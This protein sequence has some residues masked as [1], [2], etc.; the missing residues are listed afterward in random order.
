[1]L[2]HDAATSYLLLQGANTPFIMKSRGLSRSVPMSDMLERNPQI[3]HLMESG[4]LVPDV[5]AGPIPL[6]L[7]QFTDAVKASCAIHVSDALVCVGCYSHN[8]KLSWFVQPAC[9]TFSSLLFLLEFADK[10]ELTAMTPL[11]CRPWLGMLCWT[12]SLHLRRMMAW[13]CSLVMDCS[14]H[15]VHHTT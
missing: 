8:S 15:G 3:K 5:S 1:M 12:S 4:E 6:G 13:A 9:I 14:A 11:V 2:S 7:T 10:E